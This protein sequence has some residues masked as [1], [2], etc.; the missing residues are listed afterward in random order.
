VS[1]TALIRRG[2]PIARRRARWLVRPPKV[3]GRVPRMLPGALRIGASEEDA[4][5]AAV[6]EVMRSKRLFRHGGVTA[7]PLESS[8][9]RRLERS[10]ALTMGTSHALGVNSGTSALV[11]ALVGMGVGPGDEVIV[12]AYTWFATVGAI[13]AVGAVPV[14]ADV[15]ESLTL[16]PEDA[17]RK[18]SPHTRA[19][20]A[21]H[22]RGA[23]AAMDRLGELARER[24]L[25]LLE[26]AAQACG[27]SFRGR[28]LGSIGD[29]GA[30]SFQMSKIITAGEG[31]MV[32]TE[33]ATIHRRAAMYHDA[34]APPHLGVTADEWLPGV[35]LRM[36]E[37]QAAV[38]LAQL[39]RLDGLLA[40]MR[41]RKSGL[42][43]LIADRLR[44]QGV[45][46]RGLHDPEGEAAIA[47]IFF[48]PDSA[49]TE[50]VVSALADQNVPATRL[51]H[52]GSRLPYDYIDLHAYPAWA[53]IL[54]KRTLSPLGG[55]WR[56]HPRQV[57]YPEDLC[58]RTVELL[59]RAV[60]VDVGPELTDDQI[61]QMATGIVETVERLA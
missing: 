29:A 33:N 8:R 23:P 18:I 30:Y 54:R 14:I 40:D 22:M 36:P 10:F 57:G 59:R 58:A 20:L 21:V 16:D 50:R 43:D 5:V 45:V 60:H 51:Y 11:C 12:P 27:A 2:V 15:D 4:A 49:R 17:R 56:G 25:L 48:L 19:I 32:V 3:K 9:V 13:L 26:D 7:N 44:G 37:L 47:L 35:N 46:F 39:G 6:R 61:D 28:R 55:P 31:G 52:D 24:D 41:V 38:V 34:A 53:P 1:I 42:R